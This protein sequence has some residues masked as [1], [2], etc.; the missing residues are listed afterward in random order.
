MAKQTKRELIRRPLKRSHAKSKASEVIS[1]AKPTSSESSSTEAQRAEIGLSCSP[2]RGLLS[3]IYR[4]QSLSSILVQNRS[5]FLIPACLR[6][7]RDGRVV[8]QGWRTQS[9]DVLVGWGLP[10]TGD[11]RKQS[12]RGSC[13]CN[14][15]AQY[16][17]RLPSF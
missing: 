7:S 1:D 13:L 16:R 12:S 10:G 4:C 9:D 2:D 6:R 3:F 17:F 8:W 15:L 11:P 5:R 14:V